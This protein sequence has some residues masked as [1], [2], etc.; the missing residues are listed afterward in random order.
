MQPGCWSLSYLCRSVKEVRS[1]HL[2][3]AQSSVEGTG[4]CQDGVITQ[5]TWRGTCV[6]S[7]GGGRGDGRNEVG[8]YCGDGCHARARHT[9]CCVCV[10][11]ASSPT[12]R[13]YVVR[14]RG[15]MWEDLQLAQCNQWEISN[16]QRNDIA[17][18]QLEN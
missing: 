6:R 7:C 17:I 18:A 2:A 3:F 16:A 9:M 1:I 11:P 5:Q 13:V 8:W 14:L 12:E 10:P 15:G 4:I